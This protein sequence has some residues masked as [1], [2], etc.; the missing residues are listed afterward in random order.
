[1]RRISNR[2]LVRTA[3]LFA[4]L[5]IMSQVIWIAVGNLFFLRPLRVGYVTQLAAY[6]NV[7]RA[8]LASM[9]R[10]AR[11]AFLKQVNRQSNIRVVPIFP[12]YGE[13]MAPDREFSPT[14]ATSLRSIAG[15]DVSARMGGPEATT[16]IRFVSGGQPYWLVVSA[17]RPPFPVPLF[18]SVV[19]ALVVSSGG[20]YLLIARLSRRLHAVV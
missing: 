10:D 12:P 18:A 6:V 3:L 5:L 8:A 19:I 13:A 1:M 14:M 7:A 16:W 4:L 15:N 17:S 9:P 11:S 2:L 20:A